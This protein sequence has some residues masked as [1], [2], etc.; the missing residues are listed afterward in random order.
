MGYSVLALGRSKDAPANLLKYANYQSVDIAATVPNLEATI[1]IHCAG[2]ASDKE[3]L[4]NLLQVNTDGTK[5]IFN[6]IKAGHFIYISS[7]SVYPP[8]GLLHKEDELVDETQLS[9]YG[10]SKF[11]GEQWLQQQTSAATKITVIRPRAVYGA[12]DRILM[13]RILRLKKGPFLIMP[14]KLDYAISLT[15]IENLLLATKAIIQSENVYQYE[16]YNVTDNPVHQLG[17][18]IEQI[19]K[20]LGTE[21]NSS[22]KVPQPILQVAAKLLPLSDLNANTLKY[23]LCHHQLLNEKVKT[24]FGIELPH[25]FQ[26]YMHVLEKWI[27]SIPLTDLQKGAADLPWRKETL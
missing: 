2:L 19:W 9:A 11:K 6:N 26:N 3:S 4:D 25:N 27:K 10:Y 18:V 7:A 21:K 20:I 17:E 16:V 14:A 24:T 13:P 12:G 23:Y 22:V 5:N 15:N 1:C 8:N